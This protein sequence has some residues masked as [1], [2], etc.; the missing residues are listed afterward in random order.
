[1]KPIVHYDK[2][3]PVTFEWSW[4]YL[5]PLDHPNERC[6]NIEVNTSEVISYDEDSGRLETVN[7]VYIPYENNT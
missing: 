2:D 4:A 3:K 1:M 6:N 5:I 7:T